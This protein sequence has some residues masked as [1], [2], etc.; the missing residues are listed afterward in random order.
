M[1]FSPRGGIISVPPQ[2]VFYAW[3]TAFC[4]TGRE[5]NMD[6][7]SKYNLTLIDYTRIVMALLIIAQHTEALSTYGYTPNYLMRQ[8]LPRLAVPFFFMC[9]GFFLF[10]PEFKGEA[11]RKS[12]RRQLKKL[13]LL[14]AV[15][16][17]IYAPLI[18][19]YFSGNTDIRQ[20]LLKY[21]CSLLFDGSY[22]HLWYLWASIIAIILVGA[23]LVHNWSWPLIL[24][25]GGILYAVG[26]AYQSWYGLACA[27]PV[28]NISLIYRAAKF[29]LRA[30]TT[31]RN[32][33]FFGFPFVALGAWCAQHSL[34]RLRTCR[35]AFLISFFA[36]LC[37]ITFTKKCGIQRDP[38]G[39]E[40][41]ASLI[42]AT[43]FLFCALLQ[44]PG[45]PQKNTYIHRKFST[46]LYL[47]H[48][49]FLF[50]FYTSALY[51]GTI[52]I[53][54][55]F[56]AY[57]AVTVL[58]AFVSFSILGLSKQPHFAWMKKLF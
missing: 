14:Y 58:S 39:V 49:W 40:M 52:P 30:T 18:L 41:Y 22:G 16:T 48:P 11:L 36:D 9:N 42:P 21:L 19:Y 37:E 56:L 29:F 44:H 31:T 5:N 43:F 32:G 53:Q 55:S 35:V 2:G 8:T 26:L 4:L 23:A 47:V 7:Q 10:R 33:L 38:N 54:N 3:I 50:V 25:I 13:L 24:T 27:L 46:L 15:W 51:G 17:V 6:S 20:A 45:T 57:I 34:P 12:I 1:A 28:W